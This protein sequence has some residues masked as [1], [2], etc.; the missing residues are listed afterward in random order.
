MRSLLVRFRTLVAAL[1][2]A[3]ALPA[4]VARAAHAAPAHPLPPAPQPAASVWA[5]QF[6]W[7]PGSASLNVQYDSTD[8]TAPVDGAYQ[9]TAAVFPTGQNR[10]ETYTWK[11]TGVDFSGAENYGADLRLAGAPGIA[12]N[13]VVLTLESPTA[14]VPGPEAALTLATAKGRSGAAPLP[15]S[16]SPT[17][18]AGP[19][20]ASGGLRQVG[21]GGQTGDSDYRVTLVAAQPAEVLTTNTTAG[22][23]APSYIYLRIS[24]QSALFRAHPST[25]YV[26]VRFTT[27]VAPTAWPEATFAHLAARGI[28]TAEINMEWGA[29]EPSPGRFNFQ[30][31]DAD[32]AN[33]AA[34]HVHLIPIFWYSVWSGNPAPWITSYDVGSTGNAS[35]V[36]TWWSRFNRQ[37]YFAYVTT[38]IAHIKHSPGFGGAFLDYG[39]LDYMWGPAPGGSGVNG[40]ARQ[41]VARFHSWL[42]THYRSLTAFNREYG[43]RFAS[44][45][46]VPAAPPGAALFP[47][48][49]AFRDWSVG[50]TYGHLTALVRRETSAPLYYY[51][52]GGLSGAGLA[53]NL[54]DTFFQ[55]AR[56]YDVTVVLDDADHTGLALLFGSLARAYG[57]HLFEEW[58]PRPSGLHAEIAEFLG[59]RGFG[60][61]E[62]AGMDFFLYQGGREYTVG[63]PAYVRWIPVLD[64]MRGAYPL[65]PVAVY[66][67]FTPALTDPS[68]LSGLSARLATIWRAV[69]LAFTVVTNGELAAGVVHLDRFRAVLP[70]NARDGHAIAGYLAHGGTVLDHGWQ[71]ARYA[72]PYVTFAPANA[73]VEAVPTVDAATRTAWISLSGWEPTWQYDGVITIHLDGLGL[74][75][76]AYHVV[77]AATG[78]PVPAYATADTL[79]V[80]LRMLPG[81]FAIWKVLPGS[82]ASGAT[83]RHPPQPISLLDGVM[84]YYGG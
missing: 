11:L 60:A 18:A 5:E 17:A 1:A 84:P 74:P 29:V 27:T 22:P 48:Y 59:H 24:R 63:F 83:L 36:P 78:A 71:L 14:R 10:W 75:A 35:Q 56:R 13:R 50:E 77:D 69:P 46:A 42:P 44:W 41:D 16:P 15:A 65:Q 73:P 23:G 38:T 68:A 33:A 79:Q 53:F 34:A 64:R 39:W 67:S 4:G 72:A 40:Y 47:V 30:A 19:P 58:T 49:Q 32:L 37:A 66:I 8:T 7:A 81:G 57:V 80:P 28:H 2:L 31:L 45:D 20:T 9:S 70:L 52:G 82:G 54:P 12:V 25:V 76:G 21:A 6:P 61:P 43:T 3:A 62:E 51:W 26:T 55:I